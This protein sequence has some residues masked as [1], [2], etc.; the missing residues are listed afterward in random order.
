MTVAPAKLVT[1][2]EGTREVPPS[3]KR[4]ELTGRALEGYWLQEFYVLRP[5]APLSSSS[6]CL[7]TKLD[8]L[9]AP[10]HPHRHIATTLHSPSLHCTSLHCTSS[11][12]NIATA[13]ATI[14]PTDIQTI[15]SIPDGPPTTDSTTGLRAIPT[16][17]PHYGSNFVSA[18]IAPHHEEPAVIPEAASSIT[19]ELEQSPFT[20]HCKPP[21]SSPPRL[22]LLLCS[23]FTISLSPHSKLRSACRPPILMLLDAVC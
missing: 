6:F 23:L 4:E 12:C 18:G 1:R 9:V 20:P 2:R 14:I 3:R 7:Y 15:S 11:C 8:S 13:C 10:L 19:I 16:P 22:L 21:F 5:D 17:D